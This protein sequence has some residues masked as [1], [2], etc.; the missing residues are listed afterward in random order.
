METQQVLF[1]SNEWLERLAQTPGQPGNVM[2]TLAHIVDVAQSVFAADISVIYAANAISGNLMQ[3]P[4]VAGELQGNREDYTPPRLDGYVVRQVIKHNVVTVD[5]VDI[6]PE[7]QNVFTYSEEVRSLSVLALCTRHRK[8]LLAVL[9]LNFRQGHHFDD[10]EYQLLW[11]FAR[12]AA[13][14]LQ[15]TWLLRRYREVAHI[16]QEINHDLTTVD[17][18]FHKLQMHIGSIL[19]DSSTFL[20]AVYREQTATLDVYRVENGTSAFQKAVSPDNICQY[21]MKF[22]QPLLIQRLNGDAGKLPF[23]LDAGNGETKESMIFVP[24]VLRDTSLGLLSLQHPQPDTYNQEDLSILQLLAQQIVLA[25]RNIR[26]NQELDILQNVDRELNRSLELKA[27]LDTILEMACKQIAVDEAAILLF[28]AETREL[29]TITAVG[30]YAQTL[31]ALAVPTSEVKGIVRWVMEHKQSVRVDDVHRDEPWRSLYWQISDKTVSEMDVPLLDGDEVV[32]VISLESA[33]QGNFSLDDQTFLQT[34]A[35]QAVLAVKKAQAYEREKRI[36]EEWQVLNEISKQITGQLDP[37]HVFHLILEKALTLTHSTTG[38][39]MLYD[40]ERNDLRMAA[41]YGVAQDKKGMRVTLDQGIIGYVARTKQ[42]V[43]V[44]PA[45]NPWSQIY[46]DYIPGTC[47]ELA[48][49]MLAGEELRGVIDI[50]SPVPARFKESDVRLLTALADLAVIAL[51]NAERYQKAGQEA[52]RFALLYRAGQELGKISE[53]AACERAYD[54]VISIAET[55][56]Q[57]RAVIYRYDEESQDLLLKRV[58]L[59][60]GVLVASHITADNSIIERLVRQRRT[61]VIRDRAELAACGLLGETPDPAIHALVIVPVQVDD[62]AYGILAV[63]HH[64]MDRFQ[65]ADLNLFEGLAQQLAVTISR[66]KATQ[67]RKE[68]EQRALAAEEMSSIGQ[69]AFEIMHRLGNDL[70]LVPEYVAEIQEELEK[71]GITNPTI[72]KWL[73]NIGRTVHK[74][75]ELS[76]HLKTELGKTEEEMEE[77]AVIPPNVL[78]EEALDSLVIPENIVCHLQMES[79]VA[80]VRVTQRLVGDILR[81]LIVNACQAM[82][83]GGT[84]TL[85]AHNAGRWVAMKVI[86]TGIGISEYNRSKIFNLFHSTKGSFG[87]GLWSAKRNA[88][89]NHGDLKVESIPGKGTTF[90]LLLPKAFEAKTS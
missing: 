74:L 22:Q 29:E 70:G 32:G 48:V 30:P 7:Y 62:E 83:Q 20:L 12:Q 82:P 9:Y 19:N 2:T 40:A 64:D 75:L 53:L 90:T 38:I 8:R 72:T 33:R 84:L 3:S 23:K 39:L 31:H 13:F 43:N 76:N 55:H 44:D 59:Q 65:G 37:A 71:G 17:E 87:F 77:P 57:G 68:F 10:E 16:G 60:D 11:L 15:E 25:L 18:L 85:R 1:N 35:G 24:L 88:L 5:D 79:D 45:Q 67:E 78:L 86:D 36:A 89:R 69:S 26:L 49:P 50:E 21:I 54:I 66:L 14:I 47:S 80:N 51:Q 58:S 42:P 41:E 34:L 6:M 61:G 27:I 46:L 73:N 28:N 63:I 81:N 52:Q 4:V 56:S